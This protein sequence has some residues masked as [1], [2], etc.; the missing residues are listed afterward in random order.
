MNCNKLIFVLIILIFIIIFIFIFKHKLDNF[1]LYNNIEYSDKLSIQDIKDLHKGQ[2]IMT[3]IFRDFDRICR[4][5]N[6][7]Y[8]CMAGTLLGVVRHKGWIPFDADIDVSMLEKD[9]NKLEKIIKNE[10]P[11]DMWFQTYKNDKYWPNKHMNKIRH[12]YVTYKRNKNDKRDTWHNGVQLDI[13]IVKEKGDMLIVH[14]G[15]YERGPYNRNII[16][17]LKE[18]TFENIK[19]YVPNQYK[20]YLTKI[21]GDYMKLP[22]KN[23]RY[24]HEGRI[25]FSIN[26]S[27]KKKYKYLYQKKYKYLYPKI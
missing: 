20:K 21:L 11:H 10:L 22:S 13:F 17:P 8:W 26:D 27:I 4:K 23:N 12:L 24:P 6:L 9:Y 1:T 19:V 18:L 14:A 3:N 16:F 2:K 7:K 25:Q 15:G 5:Y